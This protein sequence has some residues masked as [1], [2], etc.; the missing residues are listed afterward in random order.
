VK[1]R[2]ASAVEVLDSIGQEFN[3]LSERGSTTDAWKMFRR[4]LM[5]NFGVLSRVM[6][7][8]DITELT[9]KIDENIRGKGQDIGSITP[10]EET[11]LF[12]SD[13]R[14]VH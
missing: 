12:L 8:K 9:M 4:R 11:R 14:E 5:D 6:S 7:P 10:L 3:Y 1:R 2:R 13:K